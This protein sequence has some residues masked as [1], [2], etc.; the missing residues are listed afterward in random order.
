MERMKTN[1]QYNQIIDLEYFLHQDSATDSDKLHQ[2]DRNIFLQNRKQPK[3]E[4]EATNRDLVRL[5]VTE[6]RQKEF[7]GPEKKSPGT[8][9]GDAYLLTRN[10][11]AITGI[12]IGLIAGFSFFTYTGTT[13]VNVFHFLLLFVVTQLGLAGLL[14]AASL[15]RLLLPRLKL[16]SFYFLLFRGMLNRLVAFLNK[17]WLRKMAPDQRNSVSHAFGIFKARSTVYGSIFYWPLFVLSQLFAIGFNIGLLTATLLKISTSDLAFG[18]QS[19]MQFSAEAIHRAV[20]LAAL[21]WSWFVPQANSYPSLAEIEGSR[22]ILKEGIYHLTTGAL[23]AWWPFLVFCLLCY[24]FFLRLILYFAGKIMERTSLQKLNFDTPACLA[25]IRRMRTPLVST[26]AAPEHQ[27]TRA[28][29]PVKSR[30]QAPFPTPS[31][32]SDQVVLIP[33]EISA[34]CPT[35]KLKPLLQKRGLAIKD[36]HSFMISYDKDRQLLQLL[37]DKQW[38]AGEG[39]FILMEGWMVP[40]VD[41]LSFLKELREILPNNSIIHLGLVGRPDAT[42]LTPVAPEDF[43]IWQQKVEAAGD[44]YL[45]IFPLIPDRKTS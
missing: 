40:L 1:R 39:I 45:T 44:P 34:L 35:E 14:L 29:N 3:N 6:R 24:G 12:F 41:F 22:I 20:M 11:A 15:L 43:T 5:W 7:Q 10:L 13:P 17:H 33:D 9:F 4:E 25:L 18:W 36:A 16:P 23:I 37:A 26:Q 42:A 8:I 19:T 31:N 38:Q 21:P 28:E 32:L 2:R 30:R 27:D